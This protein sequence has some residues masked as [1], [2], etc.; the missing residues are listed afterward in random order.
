M[1]NVRITNKPDHWYTESSTTTCLSLYITAIRENLTHSLT[2]VQT[3]FNCNRADNLAEL[4]QCSS[5]NGPSKMLGHI[6]HASGPHKGVLASVTL[7]WCALSS[8][9]Y[10]WRCRT[11]SL[12]TTT[13]LADFGVPVVSQIVSFWDYHFNN[14]PPSFVRNLREVTPTQTHAHT[15]RMLPKQ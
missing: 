4:Q 3:A 10:T 8:K 13:T 14:I 6:C 11:C 12:S 5:Q 7:V 9:G 2:N 1:R 15:T